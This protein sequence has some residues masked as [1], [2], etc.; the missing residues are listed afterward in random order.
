MMGNSCI[1][2]GMQFHPLRVSYF[3]FLD[4]FNVWYVFLCLF[5][6]VSPFYVV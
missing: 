5:N 6:N 2:I 1:F 3:C 4:C